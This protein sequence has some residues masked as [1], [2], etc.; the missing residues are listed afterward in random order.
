MRHVSSDACEVRQYTLQVRIRSIMFE[1]RGC[2]T[3][4]SNHA[5]PLRS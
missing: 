5:P 4:L 1:E 3:N 2:Q